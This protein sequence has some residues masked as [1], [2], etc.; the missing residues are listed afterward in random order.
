MVTL[1]FLTQ[2]QRSREEA[3][4]SRTCKGTCTKDIECV[5]VFF[6]ASYKDETDK[7]SDQDGETV[8]GGAN[9]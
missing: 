2:S 7:K 5:F 1:F 6:V 8:D 3:V 9:Q 4:K